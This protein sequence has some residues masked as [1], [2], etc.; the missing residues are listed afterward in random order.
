MGK[1]E[2]RL[3]KGSRAI[4]ALALAG[5]LFF[6]GGAASAHTA[7][8]STSLSLKSRASSVPKPG[9]MVTLSGKLNSSEAACKAASA[10]DIFRVGDGK[11]GSTVTDS[12]GNYS[13]SVVVAKDTTF[14]AVF[15][16]KIL[17]A[18]HPHSHTCSASASGTV[19]VVID[20]DDDDGGG[21]GGGNCPPNKPGC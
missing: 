19:T 3:L 12:K 8:F 9:T 5:G 16:G 10:I 7:E 6:I 14:Q 4:L 15:S 20:E 2:A 11:A 18:A 17:D 21:G 13:T 1:A